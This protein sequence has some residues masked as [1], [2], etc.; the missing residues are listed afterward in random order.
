MSA[1]QVLAL[2]APHALAV[3]ACA[4]RLAPVAML[5][6]LLGGQA[7]G[8]MVKLSVCLALAIGVH[9]AGGIQAP[10]LEGAWPVAALLFREAVFGMAV[11]LVVGLPFDAARIG[12]RFIDTFRGASAEASLPFAGSREAATGDVLYQLVVCLAISGGG[13][14]IAIAGVVRSFGAVR[15][16]AF[17]PSE[18]LALQVAG[19]AGGALATGLAVG[20]PVAGCSLA[21]DAVLALA[22]RAASPLVLSDLGPPLRILLGGAALWLSLGV[23]CERLLAGIAASGAPW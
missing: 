20:A 11:G 22:S 21:V 12:G 15:L 1:D 17:V 5:C 23:L 3:A 10:A 8:Q 16:G 13:A 9:A 6:P 7:A 4:A 19:L 2:L 14:S 18:S